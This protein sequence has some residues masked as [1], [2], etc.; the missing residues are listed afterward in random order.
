MKRIDETH[1]FNI[2]IA[3]LVGI[4][5]AIILKDLYGWCQINLYNQKNI[6][7]G[8]V[9]TYNS[10]K[11]LGEKYPYLKPRTIGVY[12]DELER[13]GWIESGNYN[14][15]TFDRT[16]WY[17]ID[18]EKYD[19]AI[20]SAIG[21]KL[22]MDLPETVNGDTE[23]CQ[24]YH[25]IPSHTSPS[26]NAREEI[27]IPI[28]EHI[29]G[30]GGEVRLQKAQATLKAYF[31]GNPDRWQEITRAA[32]NRCTAPDFA[33]EIDL[34]LRRNADDYT[35]TQNPVKALTSGRGNFVN[36]LAQPWCRQ[37]YQPGKQ[38]G[39]FQQPQLEQVTKPKFFVSQ[40]RRP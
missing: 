9:W 20:L 15:T 29:W 8:R 28:P 38:P 39:P 13:D 14:E 2:R 36:W 17:S 32:Q 24:P 3:C 19:N 6:H 30:E 34:W 11:A 5:K 37:K 31:D 22:Q 10:V 1:S 26:I 21:K 18:F 4:E 35:I 23:N 12:M 33:S 25:L 40:R 27:E 16:K 7:A